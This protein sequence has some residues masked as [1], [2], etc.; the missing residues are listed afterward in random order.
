MAEAFAC[1]VH[2][3]RRG[4]FAWSEWVECS[5][6]RYRPIHNSRAKR[7]TPLTTGN[8]WRR[9]KRWSSSRARS[10]QPKSASA[11]KPG[12]GPI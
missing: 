7:P 10:Q 2:L 3:N 5:A 1:A 11:R 12:T 4:L 8:G 9:W 6:P